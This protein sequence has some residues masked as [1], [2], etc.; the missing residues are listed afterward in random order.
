MNFIKKVVDFFTIKEEANLVNVINQKSNKQLVEEE[1]HIYIDDKSEIKAEKETKKRRFSSSELAP[2]QEVAKMSEKEKWEYI[3][4][5]KNKAPGTYYHFL[6]KNKK[7]AITESELLNH[8]IGDLKFYGKQLI[9]NYGVKTLK[10]VFEHVSYRDMYTIWKNNK[11]FSNKYDK[12]ENVL[13]CKLDRDI[14]IIN[15]KGD[16]ADVKSG[17]IVLVRRDKGRKSIF[18]IF[19]HILEDGKYVYKSTRTTMNYEDLAQ[20]DSKG[21]I[22]CVGKFIGNV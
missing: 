10:E 7:W 2:P 17:D 5:W 12:E 1:Y 18:R 8:T 11:E 4:L 15:Y 13:E 3:K 14:K 9:K 6:E 19:E 21:R 20:L 22:K 16:L